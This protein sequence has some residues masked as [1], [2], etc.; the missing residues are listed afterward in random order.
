MFGLKIKLL[1]PELKLIRES[2]DA[3]QKRQD[4]FPAIKVNENVSQDILNR[5]A[6]LHEIDEKGRKYLELTG[7]V[8]F[9]SLRDELAK[10]TKEVTITIKVK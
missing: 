10:C 4:M 7:K 9:L 5:F 8:A 1:E 2:V 6:E 3:R